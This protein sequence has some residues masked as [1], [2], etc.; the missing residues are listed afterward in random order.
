MS[1]KHNNIVQDGA[2]LEKFE[3]VSITESSSI[4]AGEEAT[5][6]AFLNRWAAKLNAEI[7][8]IEPVSDDKKDAPVW[9]SAVMWF[10]AN[11]SST[12][13]SV[14]LLGPIVFRLNFLWCLFCVLLFALV[15]LIIVCIFSVLGAKLGMRQMVLSRY[16]TGNATARIFCLFNIIGGMG[17]GV[18]NCVSSASVLHMVNSDGYS[19]PPAIACLIVTVI[20]I[21]VTFF[22]Y[23]AINVYQMW[24]WIPNLMVLFVILIRAKMSGSFTVHNMENEKATTG[25]ILSFGGVIF[26]LTAGWSSCAAD[27][28]VYMPRN[29]NSYKIFFS[30]YAALFS[31]I[32]ICVLVGCAA[33]VCTFT[34]PRWAALYETDSVGGLCYGILVEPMPVFGNI[35]LV[36]F[37]L[38]ATVN[39]IPN[40]YSIG[41]SVQAMWSSLATIPRVGWALITNIIVFGLSVACY[42]KF[43]AFMSNFMDATAYYIATYIAIAFIEHFIFRKMSLQTYDV[44]IWKKPGKLPVGYASLAGIIMGAIGVFLGMSQ[45]YWQ[46][47]ISR[48]IGEFGD[49]G[50]E[51]AILFTS[52]TYLALRPLELKYIGR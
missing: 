22:G 44:S 21:L 35:C 14:G 3:S 27:Y 49:L 50:F 46:G 30:L 13:F 42:Y 26:G 36:I 39:N 7:R 43:E 23:K 28:A 24:A 5:R 38:S 11:L 19:C 8:G 25:A 1:I 18:L 40:M 47:Y 34:N 17:W 4:P 12:G 16:L 33:G 10:S 31:S 9:I 52:V 32:C 45:E 37:S 15:G 2:G 6:L 29:T 20:T 41:L 51:V 48:P